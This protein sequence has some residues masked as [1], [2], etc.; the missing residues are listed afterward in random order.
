MSKDGRCPVNPTNRGFDS[1]HKFEG[2]V[3]RFCGHV[4][5]IDLNRAVPIEGMEEPW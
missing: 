4:R 2:T 3:C 1:P 5:V